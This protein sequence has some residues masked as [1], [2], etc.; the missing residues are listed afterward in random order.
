MNQI[1]SISTY[2]VYDIDAEEVVK[3]YIP[4]YRN[5]LQVVMLKIGAFNQ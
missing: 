5:A 1:D 4:Y 2:Y 3:R